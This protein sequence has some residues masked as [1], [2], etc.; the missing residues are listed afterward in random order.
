MDT[1]LNNQSASKFLLLITL[2]AAVGQMT[3]TIYVPAMSLI[4][5][6][7]HVPINQLQ[8]VMGAYLFPY[9]FS[10]F[11]Y[12]PL[13]DRYGRKPIILI[14]LIVFLIGSLMATT[15]SNFSHLLIGSF[16]QGLGI[17]V[18]GVMARTVMRDLHSGH[19]LHK[20]TSYISVAL[21]VAPLLA[22]LLGGIL[23]ALWGWRASFAFLA[24]FSL[25]VLIAEYCFFTET[26]RFIGS[27]PLSLKTI[28]QDYLTI[29]SN[30]E[31]L[32]YLACL[33]ATFA[34]VCIFEAIGGILF[35]HVLHY[36]TIVASLWF[37]VPLPAYMLGSYLS[38]LYARRWSLRRTLLLGIVL[39]VV[40]ATSLL[41]T[42][43]LGWV[44]IFAII[45]PVTLYLFA[46]GI[47]FPAATSG[48]L[49]PFPTLAGTAGALLGGIQNL[50]AGLCV[51][52]SAGVPQV[53]QLPL[54][55]TLTL[56]AC[57]VAALFYFFLW[58]SK[59]QTIH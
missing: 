6:G 26:N 13:S 18:G 7:L 54:G 48:A 16:I 33:V 27:K 25:L 58:Q 22:P 20:A 19:D 12:G 3:N 11:A 57:L 44:N 17:G 29:F 47:L 4:A 14:G 40:G 46:A 43:L 53:N 38:G 52:F 55:I 41:I 2:L 34:G 49:Q 32:A 8:A 1:T 45:V 30:V 28:K 9:G 31:F 35:T 10:Q 23:S 56:M 24:I 51:I 21:I 37:T 36:S 50:G 15:A 42:G 39:L 5:H 59:E